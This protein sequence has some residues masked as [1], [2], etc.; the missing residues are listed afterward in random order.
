MIVT[1]DVQQ[2]GTCNASLNQCIDEFNW[3]RGADGFLSCASDDSQMIDQIVGQCTDFINE[4]QP[5]FDWC[6]MKVVVKEQEQE[7]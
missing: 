1:I 6:S 3:K 2:V 7:L 5:H 4:H